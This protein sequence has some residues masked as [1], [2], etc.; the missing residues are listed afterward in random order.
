MAD[1]PRA[2]LSAHFQERMRGRVLKTAVFL[3]FRYDPG[4]FEQEILPVFLDVPLSH[5]PAVRVIELENVLRARVDHLA[6][7]YDRRALEAGSESAKLDVERIPVGW[8]TGYFHLKN[9]LLLVEDAQAGDDGRREQRLLV[10]ALSA[11]LTRAGWWENVEVAHVEE[12]RLGE[13]SSLRA[14]LLTLIA[15]VK[16]ASPPGE[17]HEALEA[18]RRFV[19][20]VDERKQATSHQRLHPRLYT[21]VADGSSARESVAE[22][23]ARLLRSDL[24]LQLEVIS[25]YFDAAD[26]AQPLADLIELCR[27][28]EVRVFLPRGPDGKAL[29]RGRFYEAVRRLGCVHWGKLPADLLE[30]GAGAAAP[31]RVHAKVYR[32]FCASPRYEAL[33]VGSVNLTTAGHGKR[34]NFETAFLIE[35]A[36]SR[37]PDWWLSVDATRPAAFEDEEQAGDD[38]QAQGPGVALTLRYCWASGAASALW[39]SAG[40]SPVLGVSAQGSR[41]FSL[42]PLAPRAWTSLRQEQSAA[43]AVVLRSTS[44]V[45][46][47]VEGQ[48]SSCR[49]MAW[50]TSPRSS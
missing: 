6:V 16:A 7:Y 41:L 19:V 10:A 39:D 45:T 13:K 2:V 22:F 46:V 9:V 20:Q 8:P 12:L 40:E 28:R 37:A 27:P 24:R 23:L 4:F 1:I 14:D 31:R 48:P 15:R 30:A 43:L 34:G 18:V 11:N 36:P 44:F 3:T 35:T 26:D 17:R 42:E 29:C 5:E 21:G 33:F 50:R 25:P 32:F 49:R 38:A 47:S